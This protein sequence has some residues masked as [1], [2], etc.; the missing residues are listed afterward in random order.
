[1]LDMYSNLIPYLD[2][3]AYVPYISIDLSLGLIFIPDYC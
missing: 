3:D 1:M 2:R